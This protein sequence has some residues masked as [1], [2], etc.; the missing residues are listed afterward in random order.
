MIYLKM[1]FKL[2]AA[3]FIAAFV[4]VGLYLNYI[5]DWL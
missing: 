1:F 3:V 5:K 4:W 2:W